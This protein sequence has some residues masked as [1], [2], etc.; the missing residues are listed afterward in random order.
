MPV[1][2]KTMMDRLINKSQDAVFRLDS[3]PTTTLD[4]VKLITFLDEIQGEVR[5]CM[6]VCALDELCFSPGIWK[7]KPQVPVLLKS[8][9][10]LYMFKKQ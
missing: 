7:I 2:A 4:Y 10:G 3:E 8:Q 9:N 1:M 5:L 6:C